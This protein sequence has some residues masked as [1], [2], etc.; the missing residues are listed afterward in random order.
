MNLQEIT[1]TIHVSEATIV[2]FVKK[3]GF[4]NFID[5]KL[6]I[7]KQNYNPKP[8]RQKQLCRNYRI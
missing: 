5:F 7:A 3:L 8:K 1:K 2:R 4:K 6:E